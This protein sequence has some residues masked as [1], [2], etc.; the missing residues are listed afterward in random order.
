MRELAVQSAN[1]TLTQ[2]D[3][4]Y[5]QLE[6][7]QLSEEVTR[8]GNT[9]QFNKKKLLDGS[10]AVLWSSDN[11]STKAIINGGLRSIDQ[12]GQKLTAEGNYVIDINATAGKAQ[13]QK[14]DI[15]KIKHPDVIMNVNINTNA[16]INGIRVNNLP[17]GEYTISLGTDVANQ[18]AGVNDL[19]ADGGAEVL[20]NFIGNNIQIFNYQNEAAE[21]TFTLKSINE[22]Y[23]SLTFSILRNGTTA[24]LDIAEVYLYIGQLSAANEQV[25][26]AANTSAGGIDGAV[27]MRGALGS[28]TTIADFAD[29][30]VGMQLTYEVGSAAW[31]GPNMKLI[32]SSTNTI[33]NTVD[34][35]TINVPLL[36]GVNSGRIALT[37]S[38]AAS[39]YWVMN[40]EFRNSADTVVDV[41][42]SRYFLAGSAGVVAPGT[43]INF[44]NGAQLNFA[45]GQLSAAVNNQILNIRFR[46]TI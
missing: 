45:A 21:Y 46:A 19:Q 2:E 10:A 44:A 14:T 26:I 5:I 3:R 8:I 7:D 1:D 41:V 15:F 28:A 29:L 33:L 37:I 35:D 9:T 40:A 6:I 24:G 34:V 27:V 12:F 25:L 32:A 11:N 38:A 39:G 4:G 20:K 31:R 23:N 42:T 13:V 17:A 36:M 43:V 30:Q 18:A 16:G 22:A